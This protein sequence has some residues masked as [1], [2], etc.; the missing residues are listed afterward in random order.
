MS[1]SVRHVVREIYCE[2]LFELAEETGFIDKVHEDLCVVG[3]VM[4]TEEEFAAIMNSL[5]ISGQDKSESMRRVFSGHI[6]D[7][8]LDFLS[9]LARRN[10][11]GL[12]TAITDKYGKLVDVLY[13]RQPVEVTVASELTDE[14]HDKLTAQLTK[15]LKSEVKLSINVDESIIGGAI[16]KRDDTV[17][18]NSVKA[19]LTRA[20]KA[21]MENT[22]MNSKMK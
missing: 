3:Q 8:A 18:D 15:A 13:K 17:V 10:R 5:T 14:Q 4:E 11:M 2:V 1:E 19:A 6:S 16:I 7:L 20:A 12:L 22:I 21:V 9:V